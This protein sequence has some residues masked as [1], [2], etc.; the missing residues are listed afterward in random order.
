[1]VSRRVQQG[2]MGKFFFF[3]FFLFIK[4]SGQGGIISLNIYII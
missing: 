4:V 2:T 1:V 3:F